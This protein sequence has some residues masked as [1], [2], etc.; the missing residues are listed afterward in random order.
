MSEK[1]DKYGK[2]IQ[3]GD[4]IATETNTLYCIEELHEDRYDGIYATRTDN[5]G[6][7]LRTERVLLDSMYSEYI[8]IIEFDEDGNWYLG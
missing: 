6:V 5:L 4:F 1:L 2:K 7:M 3:L 8:R